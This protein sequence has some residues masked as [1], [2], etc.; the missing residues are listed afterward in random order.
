MAKSAKQQLHTN[1]KTKQVVL[2]KDFAGVKKGQKLFVATPQLVNHYIKQIPY[3]EST[4]IVELRNKMAADH[5]CDASCPVSTAI[6]I[7]IAA[8]AAID[9][10]EQGEQSV[11]EIT[12]FWR[13]LTST[14]KITQ[15]L[16][17]D[18]NW[19]D[20]QRQLEQGY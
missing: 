20:N 19:L 7:R 6:F 15:K 3:G 5:L 17:I 8:Q 11:S 12:P 9:E 2:D 1:K 4:T 10:L 14:D 16:T 13:L 18:S